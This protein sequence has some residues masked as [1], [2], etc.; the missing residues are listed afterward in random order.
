MTRLKPKRWSKLISMFSEIDKKFSGREG[1]DTTKIK[2][3]EEQ[4][5]KKSVEG[6]RKI[7]LDKKSFG[8]F[9]KSHK[10]LR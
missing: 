7:G 6:S 9:V 2:E 1:I 5:E 3:A 8:K 4:L 10:R